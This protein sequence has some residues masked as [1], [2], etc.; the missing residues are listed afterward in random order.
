M[1]CQ[2]SCGR[3]A[4]PESRLCK[5]CD[6]RTQNRNLDKHGPPPKKRTQQQPPKRGGFRRSY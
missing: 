2:R 4:Q 5:Q 1:L 6:E 3:H